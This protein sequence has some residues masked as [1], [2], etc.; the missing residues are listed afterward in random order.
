MTS[1]QKLELTWI[2]KE[3]R[4]RLEPRIFLE[5]SELSYQGGDKEGATNDNL[6]IHGDNLLALKALEQDYAGQVKCVFIDPPYNT[7]SAFGHYDDGVEH[8][9]WLSLMRDRLELIRTLMDEKGSIWVSIDDNEMA[10]LKVMMDEIFGRQNFITTICWEKIYT[11]KNSAKHFSTMHDFILVYSKNLDKFEMNH[12]PRTEKQ[13]NN[14]KNPDKDPRGKWIDSAMHARNFYSKGSYDV[15]SPSGKTFTPPPGRYWSISKEKFESMNIDGLVW[16]GKEGKNAPRKKT[17]ITEVKQSVVPGTIW[18]YEDSGQNAEAK[19]EI[20]A[21]FADEGGVFITPK[22]EKLLQRILTIATNPGD[23]VLDSFGGTGTTG[24]VAQKMGRRWIMVELGDHCETHVAP[25]LKKVAKGED[26]GGI[27]KSV[28]WQGGGG[29]RYLRLAPS[30]LQKDEWGNWVI[31]KEYNAEMLA[32]AMCKHMGFTYAPSESQFWNHGYSTETDFIYVTTGALAYDQLKRISEEV[33]EE[34]TLL[35]C[36]KA[37]MSEGADFPNLTIKKIP[38]AILN[39][40][41]WDN[42]DYSFTL[43]VLAEDNVEQYD[44]E[45]E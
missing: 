1:K 29:F 2:G 28:N 34:R 27:S 37:F 40:C 10:Y 11:L 31:N 36:C 24:A 38:Q 12:L 18:G 5:D 25:R 19:N 6:L 44:A 7:G 42:D 33:G 3:K 14:F 26:Q 35:I 20:K 17:F 13:N 21:L 4:T 32:A 45:E 30:L 43:D 8:S 22:P 39:K 41:E 9:M 15:T 23:L 16:W